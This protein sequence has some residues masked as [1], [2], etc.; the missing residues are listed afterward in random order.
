MANQ[1]HTLVAEAAKT[2]SGSSSPLDVL[3]YKEIGVSTCG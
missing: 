2:A 1:I 3:S